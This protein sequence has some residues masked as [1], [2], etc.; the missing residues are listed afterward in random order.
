MKKKESFW[1]IG[2]LILL[3]VIFS[4]GACS[5][6]E[7]ELLYD[8]KDELVGAISEEVGSITDKAVSDVRDLAS[9]AAEAAKAAAQAEIA[10]RI[11]EIADRLKSQPVDPWDTSWL[12]DDHDFLVDNINTILAGKGM[13]GTGETIL[14]A[15]FEYSVNP[16]FAL[17]MFQ[18]EAGFAKPGTM[19]NA[20]N[21]PGNII[22]TGNC[23][24]K[25][26]G[27]SCTG[28][29]G[30]VSTNG[31]FGIYESM[32]DGIRAYFMLLSREYQPGAK[33]NCEDIPCIISHYAPPS[34]NNTTLYIE[35][36]NRW[37][38]DYQQRI[39]GQ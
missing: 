39:L 6:Y 17:A 36:I 1:G 7:E 32:I 9:E 26:A 18:K 13:E 16:A 4:I 20:N 27:S 29:Y 23:R 8:L 34:E 30:E 22:A 15:A 31:R 14:E 33:R 10:T 12:P 5:S 24:G 3:L 11:A 2:L 21:N 25:P 28:N 37:A 35:Q 38:K 19:A